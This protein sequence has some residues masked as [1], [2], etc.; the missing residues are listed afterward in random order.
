MSECKHEWKYVREDIVMCVKCNAFSTDELQ[1]E[2][3]ELQAQASDL[4][5]C[6]AEWKENYFALQ[7]QVAVLRGALCKH[8]DLAFNAATAEQYFSVNGGIDLKLKYLTRRN[9]LGEEMQ[10]ALDT[11]PAEA[12]ERVRKLVAALEEA[13]YWLNGT[14]NYVGDGSVL[15]LVDEALSEWRRDKCSS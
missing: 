7:A 5:K 3:D 1:K 10:N 15:L 4:K 11:T 12:A 2:R 8:K 6:N 14:G 9:E 13:K